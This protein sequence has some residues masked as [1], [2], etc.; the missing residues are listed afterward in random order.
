MI[1]LCRDSYEQKK[2]SALFLMQLKE[3]RLISQAAI[4]DVVTGCKEVFAH[5]IS[6]L[7]A[8]ISEKLSQSGIDSTT[9]SEFLGIFEGVTD[10]FIGLE[11]AYLQDKFITDE[12]GC[13]VSYLNLG[14]L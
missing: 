8:G 4:N 2:K 3:E 13:I 10:P 7:K 14:T 12:L 5:T 6:H 1:L 11:S 9:G